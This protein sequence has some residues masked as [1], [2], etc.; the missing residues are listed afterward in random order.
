M[1]HKKIFF[2]IFIVIALVQ[3]YVPVQMILR[4]EKVLDEG[5]HFKFKTAP[6]DPSDP[7]RG[8]YVKLSFEANTII[9]N[10]KNWTRNEAVYVLIDADSLGYAKIVSVSK[11][12][13]KNTSNYIKAKVSYVSFK[14]PYRLTIQY[15]FDRYYMEESKAPIAEELYREATQLKTT[16]AY[17]LV[18]V[19]DG[20]AVLKDVFIDN[21]PIKE[22][23]QEVEKIEKN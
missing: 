1:K 9:V 20:D 2:Y 19:K 13:P 11:E 17:A 15:P 4:K 12:L 14:S 3:L 10:D 7:F 21:T 18:S 23:I 22:I 5:V 6:I 8:K 16:I